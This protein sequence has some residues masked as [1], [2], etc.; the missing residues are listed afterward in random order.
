[1]DRDSPKEHILFTIFFIRSWW[2]ILFLIFCIVAY[3]QAVI[4]TQN[5][6]KSLE[7]QYQ[8]M[9]RELKLAYEE[10]EEL[11]LQ[12]NSQSDY[13]WVELCLIKGL[14]VVPKEY[15]K[16]YFYKPEEVK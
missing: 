3:D 11:I 1:M 13:N 5:E 4:D 15:Q 12:I 9:E 10:K 2:V 14:G 16:V 7:L 8:Q 6:K